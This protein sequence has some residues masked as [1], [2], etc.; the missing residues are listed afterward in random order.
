MAVNYSG[1]IYGNPYSVYPA[2]ANTGSWTYVSP[3]QVQNNGSIVWVQGK[4]GAEAYP[5]APGNKIMLMD[6]NDPILYVKSAD[7][8]GKPM[9]LVIYDLVERK[10]SVEQVKPVEPIIPEIDY[11]KIK[12]FIA[13]EVATQMS[14]LTLSN[15]TKKGSK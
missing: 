9:P 1:N 15:K 8:S 12:D 2:Q 11:D 4:A 3:V 5:V 7:T 10:E 14:N 13:D 6:S